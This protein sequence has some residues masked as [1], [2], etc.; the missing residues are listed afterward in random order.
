[1][2]ASAIVTAAALVLVLAVLGLALVPYLQAALR[3][4][5]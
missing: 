3:L 1:V 4:P 5:L 2:N